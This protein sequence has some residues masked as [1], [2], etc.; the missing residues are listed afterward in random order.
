M[1]RRLLLN[2]VLRGQTGG[3]TAAWRT[4]SAD[5]RDVTTLDYWVDLGRTLERGRFDTLFLADALSLTPDPDMSLLWPLDPLILITAIAAHTEHLGVVATHS[6]TFSEPYT[7][8]RQLASIDHLSRGRAGWNVVTSTSQAAADNYG[9]ELPEHDLRYRMAD[10]YLQAVKKLWV[11]WGPDAVVADRSADRL[12]DRDAIRQVRHHGDF[13]SVRGPLTMPR[14]PQT[15][16]LLAQAGGSPSGIDLA[17]RHADIVY[18]RQIDLDGARRYRAA[19]R[20][21]AVRYGREPDDV[22]VLPGFVPVVGEN[23]QDAENRLRDLQALNSLQRRVPQLEVRLQADL[24]G[25]DLDDRFPAERIGAEDEMA[26]SLRELPGPSLRQVLHRVYG[27]ETESSGHRTVVGSPAEIAEDIEIWFRAGALDGLSVH[28][29]VLPDGLQDFV[30][31]VVPLLQ[32]RGLVQGEYA[33]G[34][35][36]DKLQLPVPTVPTY[37]FTPVW[38]DLGRVPDVAVTTATGVA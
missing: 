2:A 21:A 3:H 20:D 23:R 17:G 13:V 30:D 36:R 18:T 16:P 26:D 35:L 7:V 4:T 6:T 10:D 15:V 8:A 31:R 34:T 28:P 19:V 12:L 32:E 25:V 38:D 22:R 11:A 24:G 14:S 9:R 1:T 27:P 29:M 33:A 5:V 37:G